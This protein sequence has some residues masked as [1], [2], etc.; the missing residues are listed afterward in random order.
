LFFALSKILG[1]FA[2]P[3]NVIF[4]LAFAGILLMATRFARLGRVLA[5]TAILLVAV[6]GFLPVGN[7]LIYPLE[8][9]FPVFRHDGPAPVGIVV[10]G[11]AISPEGSAAR[12]T[13]MLNE[14]SER[15]TA[16]A[17][18]A[19]RYPQARIVYSGGNA[20][21]LDEG[22]DEA[23]YALPLLQSF[24]IA[25]ER[26]VLERR[27]RSTYE[28]AIFTRDLVKPGPGERWLLVTSAHHMPRSVGVFRTAGFAV[29]PYPVDWRIR[30]IRRDFVT[31]HS[32]MS[33][34]LKRT[35]T[36]MHEWIGLAGYYLAG[37]TSE[38]F[39]APR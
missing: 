9:R 17:D 34:G 8:Q 2:H 39:P 7:V 20:N 11:G 16:V 29:E 10:L 22:P 33:D 3:S 13:A 28:N 38:F 36:A 27:S 31:P 19:R 25:P 15:L 12:G 18:L 24:G 30:G 21:L 26:V 35:D 1:F 6:I 14:A 5:V 23:A 37:K 4:T 32:L